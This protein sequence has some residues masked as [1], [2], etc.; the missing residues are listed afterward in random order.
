MILS[1]SQLKTYQECPRAWWY[2]YRK[3][4][5]PIAYS[6]ALTEGS[7]V[8]E[9]IE[10]I[11]KN[12]TMSIDMAVEMAV[13]DVMK[14][15]DNSLLNDDVRKDID[16][17]KSTANVMVSKYLDTE[18]DLGATYIK[19][20][21]P[22]IT[23][24]DDTH[25]YQCIADVVYISREGRL[26]YREI[27]TKSRITPAYLESLSISAQT[28][29]AKELFNFDLI[30][31]VVI[32]KSELRQ[33]KEES[34]EGFVDRVRD[35]VHCIIHKIE[36]P[37]QHDISQITR[38]AQQMDQAQSE[39]DCHMQSHSCVSMTSTCPYLPICANR[40]DAQLLYERSSENDK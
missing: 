27:K 11:G 40:Q 6:K 31:Y 28:C 26:V 32:K 8:H 12:N 16:I 30:E 36:S 39:N 4:I 3:K 34:V 25:Y 22:L 35:D 10:L 7:V 17:L 5:K 24:V 15:I 23:R 20:E 29:Y 1:Y 19:R 2:K 13:S 33:K 9:A 21:V 14:G 18:K 38:T 37:A